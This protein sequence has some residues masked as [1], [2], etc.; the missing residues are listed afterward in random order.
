MVR[1]RHVAQV[2]VV[3]HQS[4]QT[5]YFRDELQVAAADVAYPRQMD[6]FQVAQLAAL[7]KLKA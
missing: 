4:C 6:Y 1:D 2:L 3:S 5:D 7:E